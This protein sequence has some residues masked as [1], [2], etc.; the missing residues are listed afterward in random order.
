M[1]NE[2]A[3]VWCDDFRDNIIRVG[4]VKE[5]YTLALRALRT[6]MTA[7]AK[8]IPRKVN[9]MT[10]PN[11]ERLFFLKFGEKRGEDYCDRCGQA[12]KWEVE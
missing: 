2:E 8:Q 9:G 10:C 1:T 11:C 4:V 6:A 5:K 12:L 7:L 3:I